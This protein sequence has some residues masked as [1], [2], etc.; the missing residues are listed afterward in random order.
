[1]IAT[2]IAAIGRTQ[3][4]STLACSG[5]AN[6][7]PAQRTNSELIPPSTRLDVGVSGNRGANILGRFDAANDWRS[8]LG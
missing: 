7:Q 8:S 6:A 1:M 4:T 3:V 5:T 2:T